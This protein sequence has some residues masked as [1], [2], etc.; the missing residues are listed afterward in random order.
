MGSA[1]S[2]DGRFLARVQ[3]RR[4][5]RPPGVRPRHAARGVAGRQQG[6]REHQARRPQCRAGGAD[7][8]PRRPVSCGCADQRPHP[9]SPSAPTARLS[10]PTRSRCPRSPSRPAS[11]TGL[12]S[13]S[14][15]PGK[16]A[17]SPDRRHRLRP[18]ERPRTPSSRSTPRTGAV[19]RSWPVGIAPRS[20]V[21]VGTKL[22]VSTRAGG[23]PRTATAPSSRTGPRCRRTPEGDLDERHGERESTPRPRTRPCARCGWGCTPPA[24][25][26]SGDA[27]FV[28][29]TVDDSVS[30]ID[31][32]VDR[33]CRRSAPSPWSSP[34]SATPERGDHDGRRPCS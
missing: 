21:L 33:S 4:G 20:V 24:M 25:H 28:T 17:F 34:R 22:Y 18:G 5:R 8:L 12:A 15:L 11:S 3:H 27:L 31:T 13:L 9:L 19:T 1:V 6:G 16:A 29:N 7:L 14:A 32:R 10:E 2:P 23:P 30:V 26:A